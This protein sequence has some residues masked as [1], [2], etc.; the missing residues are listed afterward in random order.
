MSRLGVVRW[1]PN[2][3]Y[4]GNNS[5][6]STTNNLAMFSPTAKEEWIQADVVI[7]VCVIAVLLI[8]AHFSQLSKVGMT[9]LLALMSLVVTLLVAPIVGSV[10]LVFAT[11]RQLIV[12]VLKAIIGHHFA[13][14]LLGTDAFWALEDDTSL[15]V[16]NVLALADFSF[17]VAASPQDDEPLQTISELIQDRLL[18]A[19]AP[20]PKLM[21]YRQQSRLGYFYWERQNS[22]N[23]ADHIRWMDIEDQGDQTIT[24]QSLKN[25]VSSVMNSP[26]PANHAA[27]WEILVGRYPIKP[28]SDLLDAMENGGWITKSCAGVRYPVLF[29]IHHSIGDGV[30]L[31]NLLLDSLGDPCT[32]CNTPIKLRCSSPTF[33]RNFVRPKTPTIYEEPEDIPTIALWQESDIPKSSSCDFKSICVDIPSE[34]IALLKRSSTFDIS[35]C[36]SFDLCKTNKIEGLKSS[37]RT[38]CT[39]VLNFID[40]TKDFKNKLSKTEIK[41]FN[42]VVNDRPSGEFLD[43]INNATKLENPYINKSDNKNRLLEFLIKKCTAGLC[44]V[45][46]TIFRSIKSLGT[47]FRQWSVL[48][49]I[50][51]SLLNQALT[52]TQDSNLLHGPKLSGHKVVAWYFEQQDNS[53]QLLMSMIKRI[54]AKTGV[55]FSDVLLTAVSAS[56]EKFYAQCHEVPQFITVVIPARLTP[57]SETQ[58]VTKV[59]KTKKFSTKVTKIT[60][61]S[62]NKLEN[63]FSVA[64]LPLPIANASSSSLK[65]FTKLRQVRKHCELLRGSPDYLVN[66]WLLRV[67]ATLLPVWLL[68]PMMESTHSTLVLSN[69]PGPTRL[70][71][72]AGHTLHD[73]VFWV[74]NRTTTGVGVTV[75][76]YAGRLQLGLMADRALIACQQDAQQILDGVAIA[77]HQMDQISSPPDHPLVATV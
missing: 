39:R 77:I 76:S 71:K 66:Y 25:F 37:V 26:L 35:E 42:I 20:F 58:A 8:H 11:Y 49:F 17:I 44:V 45:V 56:L 21:C 40:E 41:D 52:Q 64:L 74:P 22:I 38:A 67:V 61:S 4:R 28:S 27:G 33:D 12:V 63:K 18:T 34:P 48:L 72:L 32:R 19:P 3:D 75:L 15:S 50:P 13:G 54:R 60:E 46:H 62:D 73:L 47:L 5:S 10:L 51:A 9:A 65:L 55:R 69:L 30:A 16:I 53:D 1:L 68:R 70:T 2:L 31:V 43:L 6:N 57:P 7:S 29:R 14:L 59:I 36:S 23:I 24:E